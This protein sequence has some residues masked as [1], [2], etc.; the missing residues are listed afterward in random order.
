MQKVITSY[1]ESLNLLKDVN[2]QNLPKLEGFSEIKL[3]QTYFIQQNRVKYLK[4]HDPL[5]K[6]QYIHCRSKKTKKEKKR[7]VFILFRWMF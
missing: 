3:L 7:E 6:Y 2:V 4:L 1:V 5:N